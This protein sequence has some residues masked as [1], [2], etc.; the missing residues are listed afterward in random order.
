MGIAERLARAG[1]KVRLAVNGYMPGQRIQAYVRDHWAGV[2]HD[3][4]IEVIPYA[5]LYGVDDKTVYLAHVTGREPIILEGI[6]TVVASLGHE[7]ATR[8]DEELAGLGVETHVIGDALTPRTAEEA[9]LEGLR[10][11]VAL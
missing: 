2:L 5:E 10:V 3:L 6:E 11:G 8:L 7:P 4:G 9:V 1:C